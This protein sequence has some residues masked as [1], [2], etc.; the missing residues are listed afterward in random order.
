MSPDVPFPDEV[1]RHGGS[2]LA[3]EGNDDAETV[4][5]KNPV[6]EIATAKKH[7]DDS[8][9]GEAVTDSDQKEPKDF[10]ESKHESFSEQVLRNIYSEQ[11]LRNEHSERT[12]RNEQSKR[13]LRK[14]SSDPDLEKQGPNGFPSKTPNQA[15]LE[16]ES[17]ESHGVSEPPD[18]NIV[19]WDGPDDP[20]N[21]MNWPAGRRWGMIA[22]VSAITFLT[23]LGSSM[24]A[25][26]V[27][28]VMKDF[29]STNEYLAGFVVSVYVLGFAFGPLGM[30]PAMTPDAF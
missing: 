18:P 12:L 24:F 11:T 28:L 9:N 16:E 4:S 17:E 8:G 25:P 13:T 20:M 27:P 30:Q 10:I 19:D 3:A 7:E 22:V 5:N 14:E 29:H 2:E 15:S 23:P 26:G 6:R 1:G 21:P